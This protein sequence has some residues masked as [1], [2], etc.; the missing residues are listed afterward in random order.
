MWPV[1]SDHCAILAA[2]FCFG[3]QVAILDFMPI[4]QFYILYI[5]FCVLADRIKI[6]IFQGEAKDNLYLAM[7]TL[8]SRRFVSAVVPYCWLWWENQEVQKFI[9]CSR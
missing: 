5:I 6:K 4:L 9:I 7:L 3:N 2:I 8:S 1:K